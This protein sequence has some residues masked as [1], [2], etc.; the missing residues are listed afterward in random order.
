MSRPFSHEN[1]S[2]DTHHHSSALR[3]LM[4]IHVFDKDCI[5]HWSKSHTTCS[6]CRSNILDEPLEASTADNLADHI[7]P[8]LEV[9]RRRRADSNAS[10]QRDFDQAFLNADTTSMAIV[11]RAQDLVRNSNTTDDV[12]ANHAWW[13]LAWRL[14]DILPTLVVD[15]WSAYIRF[16]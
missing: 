13:W 4:Y 16:L 11:R 12:D 6:S 5:T 3:L 14:A 2:Q 9:W 15:G 10:M 7:K 8:N 1:T